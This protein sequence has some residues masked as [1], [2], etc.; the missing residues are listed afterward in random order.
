MLLSYYHIQGKKKNGTGL[1]EKGTKDYY[2]WWKKHI[3]RCKYGWMSPQRYF[4]PGPYYFYLNFCRIMRP[5]DGNSRSKSE[6]LPYYRDVD[7]ELFY[8]FHEAV[9]S[10]EN[11]KRG[12]IVVKARDKGFSY[13]SAA[14]CCWYYTFIRNSNVGIGAAI[15]AYVA[16]NRTKVKRMLDKIP[17]EMR[18]IRL[19]DNDERIKAGRKVKRKGVFVDEGP[20]SDISFR[21]LDN[22]EVFRGGRFN[23]LY[24]DE[25]GEFRE[26]KR[27]VMASVSSLEEGS[28]VYGKFLIGGTS[29]R[30]GKYNNDFKELY[31][32]AEK[33]DLVPFMI[34]A[35]KAYW[36]FWNLATGKS[37]EKG[38]K[39]SILRER[40]K[41]A[42]DKFAYYSKI[43]EKPLN[44]EEAFLVNAS[45]PF[46]IEKLGHQMN[47]LLS[48]NKAK[49]ILQNG[50]LS[51]KKDVKGKIAGVEWKP[52]KEGLFRILHHPIGGYRYL[53]VGGIDSYYNDQTISSDSRGCCIVYC[54]YAGMDE[55][56]EMPVAEYYGRPVTKE[57]FYDECLKLAVYYD[58]KML[59]EYTDQELFR[60]FQQ[61]GFSKYLKER[62]MGFDAPTSMAINKFG[63]VMKEYQKNLMVDLIAEYVEKQVEDIYFYELLDELMRYG[64]SKRT[65]D[66]MIA[67]GLCLMHS[68]DMSRVKVTTTTDGYGNDIPVFARGMEGNI[69][70][71]KS[72][73][74]VGEGILE[75]EDGKAKE[76]H[77]D[78][79]GIFG[80][81]AAG[82]S[83]ENGDKE[84]EKH[85]NP[86][87]N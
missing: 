28:Q 24:F 47:L 65:G 10:K 42:E 44:A 71:I 87:T 81:F 74:R 43:Q 20:L 57:W 60:Y 30:L 56:G 21:C 3:E 19:T 5:E 61:K 86:V 53:Y 40:S 27:A 48:N 45:S 32:E 36:G 34:P 18:H 46:N 33:Y 11:P 54:R 75:M 37:D 82:E 23:M 8:K 64:G 6:G 14:M 80:M 25:A 31:Y 15:P 68:V 41:L 77:K 59:V 12:M 26:L 2:L 9:Q 83:E 4:I 29:N 72:Y 38:A 7:Y 1:P 70:Q 85:F 52:G 13:M 16:E 49:N 50:Y 39:G 51:W 66:R 73:R 79:R 69:V 76:F 17:E 58:C 62:P 67:F 84:E 55:V 78:G 63:V 35:T 22:P